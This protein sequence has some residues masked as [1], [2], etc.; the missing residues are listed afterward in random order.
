MDWQLAAKVILGALGLVF[1]GL[2]IRDLIRN[3]V[4]QA[5]GNPA[6]RRN[7]ANPPSASSGD[8]SRFKWFGEALGKIGG[9][10][11]TGAGLALGFGIVMLTVTSILSMGGC[12]RQHRAGDIVTKSPCA[13]N[14]ICSPRSKAS[15]P[16]TAAAPAPPSD[17]LEVQAVRHDVGIVGESRTPRRRVTDGYEPLPFP[18]LQDDHLQMFCSETETGEE[19]LWTPDRRCVGGWISFAFRDKTPYVE[20]DEF[21]LD[22]WYTESW[23]PPNLRPS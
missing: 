23:V 10:I 6:R 12:V 16:E 22:V 18:S 4:R 11:G 14:G 17:Y 5:A 3:S 1:V 8:R 2:I 20:D 13:Y 19:R 7:P 21:E 15:E 9:S